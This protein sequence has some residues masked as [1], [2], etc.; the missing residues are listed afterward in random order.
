MRAVWVGET[1]QE[2]EG[3]GIS[4][5]LHTRIPTEHA[6]SYKSTLDD[7]S[8]PERDDLDSSQPYNKSQSIIRAGDR[9]QYIQFGRGAM[10]QTKTPTVGKEKKIVSRRYMKKQDRNWSE[11]RKK[12][13][14][15]VHARA[16]SREVLF[17]R[18]NN[19]G[20]KRDNGDFSQTLASIHGKAQFGTEGKQA[21]QEAVRTS[22]GDNGGACAGV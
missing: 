9:R 3:S 15:G 7:D 22:G 12:Q 8:G 14:A 4:T 11:V 5:V 20:P 16:T 19:S 18:D 1:S 2:F 13:R 10:L 17:E 21:I 6:A